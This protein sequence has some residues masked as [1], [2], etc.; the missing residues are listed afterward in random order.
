MWWVNLFL[1]GV[2]ISNS[3]NEDTWGEQISKHII[4]KKSLCSRCQ[5]KK[6]QTRESKGPNELCGVGLDSE[7]SVQTHVCLFLW[8]GTHNIYHFNLF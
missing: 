6:L 7:V 2:C 1:T 5:R 3:E 8:Y 4:D